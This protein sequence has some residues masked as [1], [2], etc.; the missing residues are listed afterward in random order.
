[1]I[2]MENK[3]ER[4]IDGIL[5]DYGS[6]RDIDRLELMRCPDRDVVIDII[7]KLRKNYFPMQGHRDDGD[8]RFYSPAKAR[9]F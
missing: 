7:K 5:E 4:I 9:E 1:M 2:S 8:S 3:I 6:G